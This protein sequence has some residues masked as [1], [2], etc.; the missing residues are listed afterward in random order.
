MGAYTWL[1]EQDFENYSKLQDKELDEIFQEA[2]TLMPN[3]YVGEFVKEIRTLFPRKIKHETTYQIYTRCIGDDDNNSEVHVLN[4]NAS[5]R[6][7][8]ANYL[9]GLINGYRS[10]ICD[11]INQ[12]C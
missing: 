10:R 6:D 3:V 12:G 7:Y 1:T 11:H 8:V 4:L 5:N 2:R 9:F